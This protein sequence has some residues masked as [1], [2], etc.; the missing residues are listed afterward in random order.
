GQKVD[1]NE[2]RPW[3]QL[4]WTQD[5]VGF[6]TMQWLRFEQRFREKIVNDEFSGQYNFNYRLRYNLALSVPLNSKKIQHKTWFLF[7]NN[8][9]FIN[10][11]QNIVYNYF[12]Q[13]RLFAGISY[14]FAPHANIQIGYMN[15]FQQL[16]S[17]DHF[18][19]IHSLRIFVFHTID[20]RKKKEVH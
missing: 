6:R 3:Q 5:Y 12:D 7:A 19:N 16:A 13:N 10:F 18:K 8:E 11:G 15:V 14:Q 9:I 2:H 20:L 1:Y 4:Q 17:G